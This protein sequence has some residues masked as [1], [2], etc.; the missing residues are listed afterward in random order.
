MSRLRFA[1]AA[2]VALSVLAP[3]SSAQA[4][5]R[6]FTFV[7]ETTT[8][9]E[10]TWEFE[11]WATYSGAKESD[12]DFDRVD[13]RSE[14]EWGV[15]DNFQLA[16]YYT[17]RWQDGN[18]DPDGFDFR[19]VDL[20]AIYSLTNPVTD[21][22]GIALYG[23]VGLG[24]E[25]AKVEAKLLLQKNVGLWIFAWN[26][27]VEFEWEGDDYHEDKMVFEQSAGVSYQLTPQFNLGAELI[28]EKTRDDFAHWEDDELYLGPNFSYRS[29]GPWW[30]TVTPVHQITDVHSAPDIKV[31]MIFG[32]HF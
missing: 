17:G 20:E 18:S 21:P 22:I 4:G 30:I 27:V 10:G 15:T 31:R 32:W 11:Q 5:G 13:F 2:V 8:M 16:L 9:A 25:K 19:T 14:I 24:D 1:L 7:Y 23:E 3:L 6:V 28:W 26:G 29:K 12:S